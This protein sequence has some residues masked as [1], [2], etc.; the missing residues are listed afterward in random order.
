MRIQREGTGGPDPPG[1]L[2]KYRVPKHYCS[3]S[4]E[5]PQLPIQHLM[6]GHYGPASETPW[7]TFCGIS[8]LSPSHQL[9]KRCQCWTPSDK[10]LWIRTCQKSLFHELESRGILWIENNGDDQV[11]N[12][13][14]ADLFFAYMYKKGF[15]MT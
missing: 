10:T 15:L 8:I 9:K 6:L 1:K 3:G 2:Q 14:T 7:P 4:P 12:Y 13:H 5:K 11:Y